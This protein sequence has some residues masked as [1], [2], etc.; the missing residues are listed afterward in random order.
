MNWTAARTGGEVFPIAA[1][2]SRAPDCTRL[3]EEVVRRWGTVEILVT[4]TGG[5]PPATFESTG[6]PEWAA[7]VE[8]T[9]MNV[10]RL[11]RAALPH[12]KARRW[13]RVVNV[14]SISVKQP[15]E[16]LLLS[17]SIRPAVV[18]LARALATELAP[19][20]ILVN[21]VCPGSYDTDRIR[22]VAQ[23]RATR[24]GDTVEAQLQQIAAGIPLGRL[25]DPAE[26]ASVVAFLCSERA[27][28]VT[29]TTT[30]VDG[31]AYRGLM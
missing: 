30:L 25:G 23:M 8:S 16:G 19:H 1:D 5:P 2:V 11:V 24:Q 10:V 18:G 7:A 4:N 22:E 13:G 17:N 31:G 9:L 12:M 26:L 14:T 15:V 29:G 6:D 3:V 21:N 28:Y 20:G 27:S